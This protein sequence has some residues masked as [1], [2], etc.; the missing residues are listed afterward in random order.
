MSSCA[1]S[2]V[3]PK[4]ALAFEFLIFCSFLFFYLT[5]LAVLYFQLNLTMSNS[6]KSRKVLKFF[7][8][9]FDCGPA[10]LISCAQFFCCHMLPT[11]AAV[12]L[13]SGPLSIFVH[14]NLDLWW[15]MATWGPFLQHCHLAALIKFLLEHF[16]ELQHWFSARL[17]SVHFVWW[18]GP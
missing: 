7:P 18:M 5:N 15:P 12:V 16:N 14:L 17:Y 1:A 10:A 11:L 3:R 4:V 6:H 13:P 9:Y 8:F 2:S